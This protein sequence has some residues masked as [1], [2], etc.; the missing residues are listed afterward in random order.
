MDN[1]R[2]QDPPP[3]IHV[4]RDGQAVYEVNRIVGWRE[5]SRAVEFEVKWTGQDHSGNTWEPYMNITR[6]GGKATFREIVKEA[7]DERLRQLLTRMFG[8]TGQVK[9][10]RKRKAG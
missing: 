3:P 9:R 8:G 1:P 2:P 7:G 10:K 5:R 6:Y 4:S